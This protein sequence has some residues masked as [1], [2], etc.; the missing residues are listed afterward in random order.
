MTGTDQNPARTRLTLAQAAQLPPALDVPSAAR[1][2][3]ISRSAAYQLVAADELPVPVL[4]LGHTLRIPTAP[5]LALLGLTPAPT[6]DVPAD[7]GAANGAARGGGVSQ[8]V[9]IT[10]K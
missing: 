9:G 10:R 1:L 2:L 8:M 3:G 5:L 4:R 7:D 6:A